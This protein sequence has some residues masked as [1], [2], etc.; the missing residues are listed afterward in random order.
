M[1]RTPPPFDPRELIGKPC[2]Y[3]GDEYEL[4]LLDAYP[5]DRS[6]SLSTCCEEAY[7]EVSYEMQYIRGNGKAFAAFLEALGWSH[8]MGRRPR[9]V[10]VTECG[11]IEVDAGLELV[12]VTIAEAKAFIERHHRH[13]RPPVGW[14][15]GFG[16]RNWRDLV[17]VV[18]CGRPVARMLDPARVLEVTRLCV[19]ATLPPDVVK[20]ACSFL[21]GAAAREAR[22]RGFE[23][24]ITYT[25]ASE[26]AASVRAAGF[27][28]A[29]VTA[30]GS[31]D[32][33]SRRRRDAAP[34]EPKV[35]FERVFP[36]NAGPVSSPQLPLLPARSRGARPPSVRSA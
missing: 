6:F 9:S 34:T 14:R 31:W 32:T 29:A 20:D 19:D 25:L 16:V 1:A 11:H 17:G 5:E 22:R 4:S 30:G 21:Y 28:R 7:E 8:Y 33:P 3:C 23:R 12:A 18:T 2:P 13:H 10:Y 35:R 15:F 24:V 26:S 27:R 36:E